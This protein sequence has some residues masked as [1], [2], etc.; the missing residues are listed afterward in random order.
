MYIY[1]SLTTEYHECFTTSVRVLE[2][3]RLSLLILLFLNARRRVYSKRTHWLLQRTPS[4]SSCDR[5][6]YA[7]SAGSN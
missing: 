5:F 6:V 2:T 4:V 7:I 1:I 3:C